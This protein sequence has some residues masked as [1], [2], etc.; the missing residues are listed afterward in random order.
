MDYSSQSEMTDPAKREVTELLEAW[1][2]GDAGARERLLPL[3]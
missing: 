2:H 1:Q 3:V